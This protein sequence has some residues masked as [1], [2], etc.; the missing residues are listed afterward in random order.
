VTPPRRGGLARML[1]A[2]AVAAALFVTG[3]VGTLLIAL[4]CDEYT[5][6]GPGAPARYCPAATW[7]FLTAA[8]LSGGPL[9]TILAASFASRRAL[10]ATAAL[11][12]G[13]Q[14]AVTAVVLALVTS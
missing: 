10:L 3:G 1:L 13:A 5:R 4:A 8:L 14:A 6:A 2:L 12:L 9:A 11:A 7:P